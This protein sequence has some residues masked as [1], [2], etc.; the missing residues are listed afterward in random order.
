VE[1][2][3]AIIAALFVIGLLAGVAAG[4]FYAVEAAAMGGTALLLFGWLS[5][6]LRAGVF[7][8]VLRDTMA[9][10]GALF[11]LFVAATTFTLVFRAFGTDQLLDAWVKLVPGG[12]T[13]AA[14]AVLAIFACAPS[15][16]TP[17]R[18]CS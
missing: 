4:Y 12:P 1:W 13:G 3:T 14:I 15:C 18:S 7:A 10:S 9:V 8:A 5:G 17:S 6:G 16:S 11:A 2:L